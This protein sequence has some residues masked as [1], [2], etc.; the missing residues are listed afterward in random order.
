MVPPKDAKIIDWPTST[1][2]YDELGI[3][4]SKPKPYRGVQSREEGRKQVAEFKKLFGADKKCMILETDHSSPPPKK[5]DREWIAAELESI[6]RAMA[7]ITVSPLAKMMANL[8]FG[9]KPASYP[10]KFFTNEVEAKE[11]IKKYL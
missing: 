4:Y 2:W 5:E 11:W 6:T 3:L 1:M 8:F 7:I 10:L 9:F